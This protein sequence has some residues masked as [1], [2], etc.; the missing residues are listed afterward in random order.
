MP[1]LDATE[2][3]RHEA[4]AELREALQEAYRRMTLLQR[5]HEVALA[6]L[7]GRQPGYAAQALHA[8][9]VAIGRQDAADPHL[10][11]LARVTLAGERVAREIESLCVG[12][13]PGLDGIRRRL[14]RLAG[15]LDDAA[16]G[17][18]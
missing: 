10:Q 4:H 5:T 2:A 9:Q 7:R 11:R 6:Y 14:E 18:L 3:A 17:G 8:A 16:V 1:P 13:P 15:V 12:I